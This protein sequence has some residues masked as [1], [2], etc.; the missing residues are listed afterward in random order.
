MQAHIAGLE[1][2]RVRKE[3]LRVRSAEPVM[4]SGMR[5]MVFKQGF[6]LF[7]KLI[8]ALSFSPENFP[9]N[10]IIQLLVNCNKWLITLLLLKK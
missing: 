1:D 6:I 2:L 8:A 4:M 5:A 7:G 10:C 9:Y 3:D